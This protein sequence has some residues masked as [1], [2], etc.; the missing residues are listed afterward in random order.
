M[1]ITISLS[2][3]L[4]ERKIRVN[5]L[6]PGLV[7]T[8]GVKSVGFDQGDFRQHVEA[9]TPLGRI[10]QPDDIAKAAVF[11]ASNDAG[12]VNGQSLLLAGGFRQ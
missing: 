8:E 5:S 3:E 7:E 1:G 10:G 6:N 9:Q 12:W 2:R 4:G 11:F